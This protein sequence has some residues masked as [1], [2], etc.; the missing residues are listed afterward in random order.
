M[1]SLALSRKRAVAA[2]LA[3]GAAVAFCAAA[4]THA[5]SA[6][7]APY[8]VPQPNLPAKTVYLSSAE[9][10]PGPGYSASSRHFVPDGIQN[11]YNLKPLYRQGYTGKGKTIAIVDSFG[12]PQAAADLESFSKAYGLPLMCGMPGVACQ[13]GMPSFKTLEFGN[14]QVKNPPPNHSPGQEDSNAWSVEVALDI[15]YAHT[16]APGANILL[17]STPTAETLGV[18]GF[19]NFMNA[20]QYVVDHHLADVVTQSFGAAEDSFGSYQSLQNLRHAFESGTEQGITFLASSGDDGSTGSSKTPVGKGGSTLP[21]PQVGWPASDPLVTG[22]GGTNLCTDAYT[23]TTVDS[24][25]PP[26]DCS[27][28]PGERETAW[29]GSGGGFSHVF[30]RPSWQNPPAGSTAIPDSSRG[31]PD[32]S[33]DASCTT[34]V[35][36]LDTAPGYGGYYGVCGTSAASPM[37]AGVV[38][39]ADQVAGKDLGLIND[40]LYAMGSPSAANGMFDVT[41]GDNVQAGTGIQGYQAGPGWDAVTGLGTP[42]DAAV[43]VPA[44]AQLA[45]TTAP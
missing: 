34:W 27:N 24:A 9:N 17:V 6:S 35:V 33:M 22:V 30:A 7:A 13:P 23:G 42:A 12:Y 25:N 20:E 29:N 18:Q 28:Y 44:L 39:I 40:D 26:T 16:T 1:S 37:F 14:H 11:S 19:P 15:E 5:S 10:A 32:I 36:V 31:V 21:G 45:A 4:S 38:A 8:P 3:A 43:F 41:K 2:T